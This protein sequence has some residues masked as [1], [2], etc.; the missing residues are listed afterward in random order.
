MKKILT[1]LYLLII[2]ALGCRDDDVIEGE[3]R[4][5]INVRNK[6]TEQPIDSVGFF[7]EWSSSI[8]FY[9]ISN[10]LSDENGIC[11]L[12][13]DYEYSFLPQYS[14]EIVE[15]IDHHNS[16]DPKITYSGNIFNHQIYKV[17]EFPRLDFASKEKFNI[18]IN[19]IPV[20]EIA[21]DYESYG[22]TDTDTI[23]LSFYENEQIIKDYIIKNNTY[24]GEFIFY[25]P[26]EN[27]DTRI[28]FRVRRNGLDII[29][30]TKIFNLNKFETDTLV[31][32]W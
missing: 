5:V 9:P 18:N 2:I 24:F 13:F 4:V 10:D 32:N 22:R 14:F 1:L 15:Y 23:Y 21:V 26:A 29:N 28:N 17:D 7:I 12:I 25:F 31:I 3:K 30:G 11:E 19:L 8:A 27:I 6:I 16:E 20:G